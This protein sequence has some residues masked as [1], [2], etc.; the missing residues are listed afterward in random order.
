MNLILLGAPGSGKGTLADYLVKDYNI[1]HISTGD[2][3]RENI[4]NRTEIG[5]KIEEK[6]KTGELISDDITIQLVKDRLSKPDTKNGFI[7][8]GFPRNLAQAEGLEK[9]ARIDNVILLEADNNTVINRL[10]GR[11]VCP[12]CKSTFNIVNYIK[13]TCNKCGEVLVHREDDKPETVKNRLEVYKKQTAPLIDFYSN[14][15]L[16]VDGTLTAQKTYEAVKA[17]MR[18]I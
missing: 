11:R 7:L 16:R 2:I 17:S 12:N 1:P 6:M 5:I 15:I 9:F 4:K 8:D 18:L 10:N 3:F 13:N 14:K